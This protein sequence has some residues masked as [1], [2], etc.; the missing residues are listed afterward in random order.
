M[1]I[2]K[3]WKQQYNNLKMQNIIEASMIKKTKKKKK[4]NKTIK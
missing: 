4:K 2:D 3:I 1:S